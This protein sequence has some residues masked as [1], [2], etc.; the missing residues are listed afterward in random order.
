MLSKEVSSTIFE[1]FDMTRPEIEPR[2]PGPLHLKTFNS[3]NIELL[4]LAILETISLG[5]IKELMLNR[6]ISVIQQ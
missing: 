2:S 5:S 1:D 3:V 4:E 6:I